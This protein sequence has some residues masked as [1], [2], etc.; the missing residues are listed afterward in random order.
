MEALPGCTGVAADTAGGTDG[1][2]G[3]RVP[4]EVRLEGLRDFEGFPNASVSVEDLESLVGSRQQM[5]W[6]DIDGRIVVSSYELVDD[7]VIIEGDISLGTLAEAS[8]DQQDLIEGIKSGDY[9]DDGFSYK[10]VLDSR[11]RR[12]WADHTIYYAFDPALRR[13]SGAVNRA[14]VQSAVDDWNTVSDRTGLTWVPVANQGVLHIL[15]RGVRFHQHRGQRCSSSIGAHSRPIDINL[16]IAGACFFAPTVMHEMGHAM[17]LRHEAQRG[18]R[19][20]W[21]KF[22][23]R[24]YSGSAWDTYRRNNLPRRYDKFGPYD[25]ESIMQYSATLFSR[26]RAPGSTGP[27]MPTFLNREILTL[28]STAHS[29]PF[30]AIGSV[31]TQW[32]TR[33]RFDS[34]GIDLD[35]VQVVDVDR[36]GAD[37]LVTTGSR[38]RVLWSRFGATGWVPLVIHNQPVRPAGILRFADF[39]GDNLIDAIG[40]NGRNRT[41]YLSTVGSSTRRQRYRARDAEVGDLDADGFD[42][43][44]L[45]RSDGRWDQA[46]GPLIFTTFPRTTTNMHVNEVKLAALGGESSGLDIIGFR[47]SRLMHVGPGSTTWQPVFPFTAQPL[48]STANRLGRLW[49]GHVDGP[50]TDPTEP[51]DIVTWSSGRDGSGATRGEPVLLADALGSVASAPLHIQATPGLPLPE[52]IDARDEVAVGYFDG[53]STL[54]FLALGDIPPV[55]FPAESDI[56]ALGVHYLSRGATRLSDRYPLDPSRLIRTDYVASLLPGERV[57]LEGSFMSPEGVR[58]LRMKVYEI[59]AD[60]TLLMLS[61]QDRRFSTRTAAYRAVFQ[62]DTPGRYRVEMFPVRPAG[63]PSAIQT[64]TW[65]FNVGGIGGSTCG[66]G[67]VDPGEEC[68]TG[69]ES[70]TCDRDCTNVVCG[71]AWTNTAAGEQCDHGLPIDDGSSSCLFC[72]NN[73]G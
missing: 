57:E 3:A 66:D 51:V 50:R 38:G 16:G 71:D 28:F 4:S 22:Y 1:G 10:S 73:I 37:D 72:Q 31:Q 41:V 29:A 14:I 30:G 26:R 5:M 58:L 54:S 52:A 46:L 68:D 15:G 34:R 67:A 64:A 19:N 33:V 65:V 62:Q 55:S 43:I 60:G 24:N 44:L 7:E 47:G 32:N 25:H 53:G 13:A 20:R 27:A 69:G 48:P 39:D 70:T 21:I 8:A 36:D 35:H 2:T 45:V 6:E 42:D 17:G 9:V 61:T 49:F 18:D 63:D 12:K 11:R 59:R 40:L 56:N 23:S